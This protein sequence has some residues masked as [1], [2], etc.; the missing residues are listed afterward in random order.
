MVLYFFL[1]AAGGILLMYAP[2]LEH[3]SF[4]DEDKKTL[5]VTK[6]AQ[7]A[8]KA[9]SGGNGFERKIEWYN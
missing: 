7:N 1:G 4:A 6:Y 8:V 3:P 2:K 9:Q 5:T